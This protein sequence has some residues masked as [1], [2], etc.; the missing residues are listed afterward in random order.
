MVQKSLQ[1]LSLNDT[2]RQSSLFPAIGDFCHLLKTFANS[3][4]P[5]PKSKISELPF[6]LILQSFSNKGSNVIFQCTKDCGFGQKFRDVTCEDVDHNVVNDS[7][8]EQDEKPKVKRRCSEF[9]CPFMWN[10]SPWSEVCYQPN[11]PYKRLA[12]EL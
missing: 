4:D 5:D 12:Y 10:T 2:S 7:L 3:L 8:C 9:P 6:Y 1:R 11:L